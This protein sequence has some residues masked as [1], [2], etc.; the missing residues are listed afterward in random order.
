MI[1]LPYSLFIEATEE[2]DFFGFYSEEL[3]GFSGIGRSVED[4]LY[5]AKWAMK[6]H[7]ELLVEQGLPVPPCNPD[8]IVTIH[9][10][11]MRTI[12]NSSTWKEHMDEH[13]ATELWNRIADRLT[14]DLPHWQQRIVELKQVPAVRAR[15]EGHE[16]DDNEVFKGLVL[17]VLSNNIDWAKVERVI[18]EL[19]SLFQ[20]FRIQD[21]AAATAEDI[22]KMVSWFQ[23]HRAGSMTLKN[24][25][26]RL[27][28]AANRLLELVKQHN[29]LENYF[30]GIISKFKGDIPAVAVALGGTASPDKLPSLGIP[31]AAEFLKNI[32]YDV[33]KPDRHV[34]R[35][36]GSFGWV[37]FHTWPD[38]SGTTAPQASEP[39]MKAVMRRVAEFAGHLGERVTYVDN[40]VWLLCAKSGLHLSNEELACLAVSTNAP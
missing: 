2:P 22:E 17:S 35:A 7:V 15:A 1:V 8:P 37:Q 34:N 24:S 4:C 31:L 25:L 19:A 33:A 39:E 20:D 27:N 3:A 40:A 32:G 28:I 9:N 26:S 11:S 21:Y 14:N 6:E 29:S 30:H 13:K 18:P 5:Q 16:W 36:V 10:Y 38:R 23:S 12:S